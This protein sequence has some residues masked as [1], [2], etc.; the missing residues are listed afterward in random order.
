MQSTMLDNCVF[1]EST[2]NE[3]PLLAFDAQN[4]S[5][6]ILRAPVDVVGY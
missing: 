3:M 5:K 1:I 4:N 6:N 2:R